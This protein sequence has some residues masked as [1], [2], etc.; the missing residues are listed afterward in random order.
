MRNWTAAQPLRRLP[1]SRRARAARVAAGIFCA[2]AS[3]L[4]AQ[5]RTGGLFQTEGLTAH[6]GDTGIDDDGEVSPTHTALHLWALCPF[7]TGPAAGRSV[8][9]G[10]Q[11]HES[12][13]SKS[14]SD[15]YG[16]F[17]EAALAGKLELEDSSGNRIGKQGNKTATIAG[18]AVRLRF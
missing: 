4:N 14:D 6:C 1:A 9:V 16:V 11:D 7:D 13:A 17:A 18:S 15:T 8:R 10:Q 2:K 5:P 12:G 3:A